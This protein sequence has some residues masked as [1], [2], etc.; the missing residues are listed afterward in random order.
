MFAAAFF[1]RLYETR[2][3]YESALFA[4]IAASMALELPGT[5]GVPSRIEIDNCLAGSYVGK[6]AKRAKPGR[7]VSRRN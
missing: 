1:I 3:P 6:L 7:I 5:C 2:D 4:N